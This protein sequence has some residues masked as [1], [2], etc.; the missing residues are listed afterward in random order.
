MSRSS[1]TI[2]LYID[3][4]LKFKQKFA[5]CI[6]ENLNLNFNFEL[7]IKTNIELKLIICFSLSFSF[8]KINSFF[9]LSFGK[10]KY[11]FL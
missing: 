11:I 9:F 1:L 3:S 8:S 7:N 5:L 2:E 10:L 4:N 6:V